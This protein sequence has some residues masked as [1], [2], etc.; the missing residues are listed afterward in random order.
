[1]LIRSLFRSLFLILAVLT[2]AYFALAQS[3]DADPAG[4]KFTTLHSFSG[5]DGANPVGLVQATNGFFYGTTEFGGGD[6][7]CTTRTL[8]GTLF[9]ITPGGTLTTVY[10]FC[11]VLGCP[12]PVL[13]GPESAPLQATSGE[14]YGT[15]ITGSDGS[16]SI[17][18]ATPTGTLSVLYSFCSQSGC[19]DGS[20]PGFG[21]IQAANG[22]F[23]GVTNT[24]GTHC[25]GT[26]FKI[27]PAGALTTLYDFC[28][29]SGCPDGA[30]PVAPLI[31]GTDG[32]FYGTTQGGGS[33]ASG[34]VFK[35]TPSGTLTTLYNFCSQPG[36]SDGFSVQTALV[37]GSN[38][39]FYG[40]TSQG[41]SNNGGTLFK[42]TATGTFS[43]IYEFCSLPNCADGATPTALIRSASGA[44]YG[45]T[46]NG[47]S[48]HG[49][50]FELTASGLTTLH[51]FCAQS[52][53]P[54]G[55][56]PTGLVQGTNG[57]FYGTTFGGGAS[58]DGTVFSLSTGQAPFIETRPTTGKVGEAVTILGYN[59]TGATSVTFNGVPAAIT[60]QAST[61]IK[62]SV[63]TGA[64]TGKVV[65]TT[66]SRTLS[67]N[68]NFEVAP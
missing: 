9:K 27:T 11:G 65:V 8:C 14:L 51:S 54:D 10:N 25:C 42:I 15:V 58:Q 49:T 57:V 1:M 2:F 31:Q 48:G 56:A 53:C 61:E 30:Q 67:S 6:S 55:L 52:G 35:I 59:L 21:L 43:T 7:N 60:L 34:T 37:Q 3:S 4:T 47:G 16:G 46:T 33:G 38:G 39:S 26:I 29:Q 20:T 23:Y 36:C 5:T 68:V 32:N 24:A 66:P 18:K 63:P 12:S 13:G 45:V 44:F 19:T 40:A 50:I 62:T 64:T 17:F 28:A 41:G 22:E